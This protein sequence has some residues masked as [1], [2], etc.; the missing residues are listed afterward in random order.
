MDKVK[1]GDL[2]ALHRPLRAELDAAYKRVM[3]S[4]WFITGIELETF[5]HEFA[6]YC[7]A[8]HAIGVANGLEALHLILRAYGIGPGDEVIVPANTF[9]ATWLAVSQAGAM[10][11]PVEPDQTTYNIDPGRIE[12][13][14]TSR[15]RAII[16]ATAASSHSLGRL[17]R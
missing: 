15:T 16:I 13:K 6:A 5:E 4:G 17:C 14:V 3:D 10:P 11:V 1:F 7:K 8:K 12:A 2:A 9:I